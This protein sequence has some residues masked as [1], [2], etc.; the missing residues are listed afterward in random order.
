M[1]LKEILRTIV[2][3]NRVR[4][5]ALLLALGATVKVWGPI[6]SGIGLPIA[7]VYWLVTQNR[8]GDGNSGS[9][10]FRRRE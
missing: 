3:S 9:P 10:R 2:Q 5:F 7:G 6:A 8:G 1:D 4:T